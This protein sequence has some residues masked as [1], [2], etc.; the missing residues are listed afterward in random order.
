MYATALG[1]IMNN[2]TYLAGADGTENEME[3]WL[4]FQLSVADIARTTINYYLF[5]G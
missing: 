3:K 5:I 1:I 4:K 2:L